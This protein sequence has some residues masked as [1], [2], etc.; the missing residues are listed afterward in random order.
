ME[1]DCVN[2]KNSRICVLYLQVVKT[3][4]ETAL[5]K[6]FGKVRQAIAETCDLYCSTD[7]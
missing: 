1:K 3:Q 2:C 6:D 7:N 5:L 4:Y